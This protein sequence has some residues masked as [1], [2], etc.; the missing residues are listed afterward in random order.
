MQWKNTGLKESTVG[1]FLELTGVPKNTMSI[2]CLAPMVG[3]NTAF[4]RP[5]AGIKPKGTQAGSNSQSAMHSSSAGGA[6][7]KLAAGGQASRTGTSTGRQNLL[8][9]TSRQEIINDAPFGLD[10]VQSDMMLTRLPVVPLLEA[11][12][13][14]GHGIGT[15]AIESTVPSQLVSASKESAEQIRVLEMRLAACELHIQTLMKQGSLF[16][17]E[18]NRIGKE[19]DRIGDLDVRLDEI[20]TSASTISSLTG[21]T[22]EGSLS[23]QIGISLLDYVTPFTWT[24]AML[25]SVMTEMNMGP[26]ALRANDKLLEL[27]VCAYHGASKRKGIPLPRLTAGIPVARV[28]NMVMDLL[29]FRGIPERLSMAFLEATTVEDYNRLAESPLFMDSSIQTWATLHNQTLEYDELVQGVALVLNRVDPGVSKDMHSYAAAFIAKY[30]AV[31]SGEGIIFWS[32]TSQHYQRLSA[33]GKEELVIHTRIMERD[34]MRRN[35][36][37]MVQQIRLLL[38]SNQLFT[39][40]NGE[41]KIHEFIGKNLA[42]SQGL[43]RGQEWLQD[44]AELEK[45]LHTYQAAHYTIPG[46]AFAALSVETQDPTAYPFWTCAGGCVTTITYSNSRTCVDC[47]RACCLDNECVHSADPDSIICHGCVSGRLGY[48]LAGITAMARRRSNNKEN[49]EAQ[50]WAELVARNVQEDQLAGRTKEV[51]GNTSL[52][53][54]TSVSDI[55]GPRPPN[56]PHVPTP[57]GPGI[58]VRRAGGSNEQLKKVAHGGA[59][60]SLVRVL[61]DEDSPPPG[62]LAEEDPEALNEIISPGGASGPVRKLGDIKEHFAFDITR[63]TALAIDE[64]IAEAEK[65]AVYTAKLNILVVGSRPFKVETLNALSREQLSKADIQTSLCYLAME[66]LTYS[67]GSVIYTWGRDGTGPNHIAA[68]YKPHG[69]AL[70]GELLTT[71]NAK[72]D[73]ILFYPTSLAHSFVKDFMAPEGPYNWL[74][75]R[76]KI[77]GGILLPSAKAQQDQYGHLRGAAQAIYAEGYLWSRAEQVCI[78]LLNLLGITIPPSKYGFAHWYY[79]VQGTGEGAKPIPKE[80]KQTSPAKSA[81]KRKVNRSPNIEDGAASS[82]SATTDHG[83]KV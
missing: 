73:L 33:A 7:S 6:A 20:K 66:P 28:R 79:F 4:I 51:L 49:F 27:L 15:N 12:A 58:K 48:A 31:T 47:G 65:N 57:E 3:G 55:L 41:A 22:D 21:S 14:S 42:G 75:T 72:L 74:Y 34:N 40:E 76:Q 16:T 68:E 18:L 71:R 61:D 39:G 70:L 53:L 29:T 46:S 10:T 9:P 32:L 83:Q 44:G 17:T 2:S 30:P 77:A 82:T 50:I 81:I 1:S 45:A 56:T 54:S 43:A 23:Q 59:E 80:I 64:I 19:C 5:T 38:L 62:H 63:R 52:K 78:R 69:A 25:T 26:S 8:G 36:Q 24:Q 37:M 67:S 11:A 35:R 13:S 60:Q